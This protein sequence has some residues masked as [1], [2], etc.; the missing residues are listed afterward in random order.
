M[1]AKRG[2]GLPLSNPAE[3]INLAGIAALGIGPVA[4]R[5][6][7]AFMRL[8]RCG[9]GPIFVLPIQPLGRTGSG[10]LE[11]GAGNSA[12][13]AFGNPREDRQALSGFSL[14]ISN[15]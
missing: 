8:Q 3:T 6:W 13:V 4:D 14:G 11:S 1:T 7:A 9:A 12:M 10:D 2:G 5:A 15:R